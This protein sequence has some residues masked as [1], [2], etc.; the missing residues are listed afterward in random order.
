VDKLEDIKTITRQEAALALRSW[1]SV[2]G[3]Q[4][5]VALLGKALRKPGGRQDI[6]A[7]LKEAILHGPLV[8]R[9]FFFAFSSIDVHF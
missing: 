4:S 7:V 6:L 8:S 1:V 3:L 9:L 2:C 5:S